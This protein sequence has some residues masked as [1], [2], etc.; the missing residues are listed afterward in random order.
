MQEPVFQIMIIYENLGSDKSF[1]LHIGFFL[2]LG[3]F[4]N[5]LRMNI[6]TIILSFRAK[7]FGNTPQLKETLPA[8]HMRI[9]YT[10]S[11]F[12]LCFFHTHM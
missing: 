1:E 5:H 4:R 11:S 7:A 6:K 2:F 9:L 12:F 10:V 3:D 8:I